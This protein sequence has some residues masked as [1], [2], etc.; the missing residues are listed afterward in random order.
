MQLVLASASQSRR[1]ML[2]AAGVSFT[3]MS[4]SVD[5]DEVKASLKVEGASAADVAE[6]LAEMKALRI[7]KRMPGCLVLGAD[8]TLAVGK[9]IFDKPTSRAD[10]AAQLRFLAG[11]KHALP[12]AAVIAENGLSVW[13]FIAQPK[14]SFRDYSDAFIE[15][16]LDQAGESILQTVG[17]CEIEGLGAQLISRMQGDFFAVLGL[18]L[19]QVLDYLRVRGVIAT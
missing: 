3:V 11:G 9:E 4:P 14:I 18:P 7:S 16:Y 10:A 17:A 19:L 15:S 13:R 12:T 2:E 6:V 1:R 8:Q 5:E